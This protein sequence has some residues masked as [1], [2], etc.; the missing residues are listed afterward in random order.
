MT[1]P[2]GFSAK[3]SQRMRGVRGVDSANNTALMDRISID[4]NCHADL[5]AR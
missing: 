4:V 5:S 1:S 2:F 3:A